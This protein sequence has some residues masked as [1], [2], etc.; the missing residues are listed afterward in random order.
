M[1]IS[2]RHTQRACICIHWTNCFVC[3]IFLWTNKKKTDWKP[4]FLLDVEWAVCC[5]GFVKFKQIIWKKNEAYC[6]KC[7]NV[8]SE[9]RVNFKWKQTT[10]EQQKQW[11][12]RMILLQQINL[13]N[14]PSFPCIEWNCMGTTQI[15]CVISKKYS[16]SQWTNRVVVPD[17]GRKVRFIL[18]PNIDWRGRSHN[19]STISK[20]CRFYLL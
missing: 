8:S 20:M 12:M 3:F 14:H 13:M 16:D 7:M 17:S 6:G 19:Y 18:N 1:K 5:D 15:R 4:T 10:P 11:T 2:Q 9:R